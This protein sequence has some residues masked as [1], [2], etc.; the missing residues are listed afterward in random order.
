MIIPGFR[1]FKS[2]ARGRHPD[3]APNTPIAIEPVF[4]IPGRRPGRF[5]QRLETDWAPLFFRLSEHEL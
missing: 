5:E 1:Q 2:T 3:D 4:R